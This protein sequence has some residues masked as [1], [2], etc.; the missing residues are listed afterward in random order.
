MDQIE[1]EGGYQEVKV[2][3]GPSAICYVVIAI[4]SAGGI[5]LRSERLLGR[6][7]DC[8]GQ[9]ASQAQEVCMQ[10]LPPRKEGA[11]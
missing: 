10:A 6:E 2:H 9:E 5:P 4:T 11:E 8:R 1:I 3:Y 7:V